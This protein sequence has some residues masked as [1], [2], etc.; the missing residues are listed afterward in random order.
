M[1]AQKEQIGGEEDNA[2]VMN[3]SPRALRILVKYTVPAP[4]KPDR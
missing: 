3:G 2:Q 4:A 1:R